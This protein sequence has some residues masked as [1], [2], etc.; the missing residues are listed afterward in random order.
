LTSN[1]IQ[2]QNSYPGSIDLDKCGR[3][4][5][6]QKSALFEDLQGGGQRNHCARPGVS[7][8]QSPLALVAPSAWPSDLPLLK[9]PPLAPADG[10]KSGRG[11]KGE[12]N[13]GLQD[14]GQ[15]GPVVLNC[16]CTPPRN[17]L[18]G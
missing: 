10:N 18:K 1:L 15:M 16:A 17:G 11:A 12:R 13:S 3:S 4:D 14:Q 2:H 7:S 5:D 6:R 9:P 8:S